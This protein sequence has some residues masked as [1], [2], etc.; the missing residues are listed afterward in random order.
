MHCLSIHYRSTQRRT[1][2]DVNFKDNHLFVVGQSAEV[3]LHDANGAE[4]KS[5]GSEIRDTPR[6]YSALG[7]S[8]SNNNVVQVAVEEPVLI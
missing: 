8:E 4:D 7:P 3:P 5:N 1:L 6:N 2:S